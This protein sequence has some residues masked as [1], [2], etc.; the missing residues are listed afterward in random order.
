MYI[1]GTMKNHYPIHLADLVP[2]DWVS[3]GTYQ[4]KFKYQE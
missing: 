1:S 3:N 2:M 4:N